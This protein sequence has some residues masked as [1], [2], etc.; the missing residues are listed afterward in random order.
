MM[1][2][3]TKKR[4]K[5]IKI[6]MIK[7]PNRQ[8]HFPETLAETSNMSESS[9]IAEQRP[10]LDLKEHRD[11]VEEKFKDACCRD[12]SYF[13]ALSELPRWGLAVQCLLG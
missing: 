13:A 6:Q 7:R 11:P 3:S 4:K 8:G 5:T 12:L 1:M 2:A 10:R 9:S